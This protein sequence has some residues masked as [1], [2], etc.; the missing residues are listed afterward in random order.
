MIKK[1]ITN[2]FG[3]NRLIH[4]SDFKLLKTFNLS[5]SFLL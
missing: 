3:R 4:N 5:Y 1:V 2:L